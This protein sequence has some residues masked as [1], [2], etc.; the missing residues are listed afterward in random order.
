[1]IQPLD[2]ARNSWRLLWIDLEEPVPAP[3]QS[4]ESGTGDYCLPTCLLV[5]T[6]SGKPLCPPE[7][8][9]ELD[10]PRAEQLLGRLFDEHGTP[11]RLT[12]AES[13]DWDTEAWRSFAIDCR[14]E[15]AF[16]AFPEAKPGELL[17]VGRRIAQRLRGEG[18][19]SPGAI[20]RGLVATARRLRSPERKSAHLRKA[21]E[22]DSECV[23]ARIEL[24]DADYQSARWNEARRGYQEVAE[25][26]ERR[27]RGETPEWWEDHETRPYMRALYGRAMT[28]WHQ[29]RFAE[30][31]KDLEKLLQLNP[32]DNQGVRFLIPL[33]HLLGDD[34]A[35]ALKSLEEYDR[36]YPDD[37]CEP[38]LLFGKGLAL[39]RLGD[40]EP[41]RAAYRTAM[42]Q[43]LYIT[44]MLL[45]LPTPPGDIWHPNDRSEIGYAQDFM[46]SYAILWDREP[47][48]TRFISE[49]HDEVASEIEKILTLRRTMADWQDQRYDRDFKARWKAMIDQDKSLTGS[50]DRD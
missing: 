15:I 8:L 32:R 17:Q 42:L 40:D 10:Q 43:N 12:I 45:D 50:V 14:I 20:A 3:A 30:T 44:P 26:E 46:Q 41:A 22:Q 13:S 25:R 29:G 7:I 9:E 4:G 24:A 27:W 23:L 16:G 38:S 11:D 35:K 31:A 19:H 39:W 28:E 48:A 34:D 47:A 2:S 49:L 36:N 5:T 33:V 37:Y 18:F 21:I 1:M 6:A